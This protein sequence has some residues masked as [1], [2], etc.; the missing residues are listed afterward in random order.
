[1]NVPVGD[2]MPLV[3]YRVAC[4]RRIGMCGQRSV[5]TDVIVWLFTALCVTN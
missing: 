2:S 4:G 5:P 1:M 3:E